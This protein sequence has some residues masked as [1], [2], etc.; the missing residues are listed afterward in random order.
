M[1]FTKTNLPTSFI[2][3]ASLTVCSNVLIGGSH[4]VSVGDVLP[5]LIGKG[6]KPQI[7]IQALNNSKTMEFISIVENSV[8]KHPAVEILET[9]GSIVVSIQGVKILSVRKVDEDSAAVDSMDLRPIGLN[10]HGNSASMHIGTS[11]FSGN[12]M[13]GGGVL[14]GLG[15]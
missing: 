11:T 12:T 4:I 3:Y 10:L 6:D 14:L 8:S 7:W 15:V 9:S 2:P 5:L 1:T 13:S